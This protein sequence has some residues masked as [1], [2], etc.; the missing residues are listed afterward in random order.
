MI[1]DLTMTS[2]Q[3][4]THE[5]VKTAAIA[6]REEVMKGPRR[7]HEFETGWYIPGIEDPAEVSAELDPADEENKPTAEEFYQML[8]RDSGQL[9]CQ[10][11]SAIPPTEAGDASTE[12]DTA[13]V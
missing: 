10:Q 8:L 12:G 2:A 1:W 7:N 9:N 4:H 11:E 3:P 5:H 13:S 6:E